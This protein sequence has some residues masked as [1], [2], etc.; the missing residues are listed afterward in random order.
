MQAA[1]MRPPGALN[2]KSNALRATGHARLVAKL[3]MYEPFRKGPWRGVCLLSVRDP[4]LIAEFTFE[5]IPR[6]VHYVSSVRYHNK[7]ILPDI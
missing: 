2:F 1:R 6:D 3:L 7:D 5:F 4:L